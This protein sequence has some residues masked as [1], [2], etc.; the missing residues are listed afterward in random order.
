MAARQIIFNIPN[1]NL[2]TPR[3]QTTFR[4]NILHDL[5]DHE[6]RSRYR[7]GREAFTMKKSVLSVEEQLSIALRFYA[8]GS[9]LQVIGDTLGYD[10]STVSR[11][12]DS[13]T[14]AL[15]ARERTIY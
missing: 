7:F 3:K 11:A 5:T 9:F 10:K 4:G 13:V 1:P 15:L 12:V 8:I 6:M 14:E 2:R